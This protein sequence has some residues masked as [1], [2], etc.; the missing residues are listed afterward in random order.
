MHAEDPRHDIPP[1]H[2]FCKRT[3]RR[4]PYLFTDQEVARL[5]IEAGKLNPASSL[6]PHTYRTIFGLLASTGL[7]ISEVLRL[8]FDDV[9]PDGLAIR[10]TKFRKS[11]LVPLHESVVDALGFYIERRRRC[12]SS[13]PHIF[14]SHRGGGRLHYDIVATTF[15]E[16]IGAVG[17]PDQ[18]NRSRPRLHDL[19]QNAEFWKMPNHTLESVGSNWNGST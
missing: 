17:I 16:I 4:T 8:R 6:R 14:V 2:V 11:R 3:H 19:R 5:L 18:P 1:S 10:E 7:R 12:A 15:Q 13:D 9:T